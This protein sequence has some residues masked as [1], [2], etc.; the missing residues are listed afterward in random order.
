MTGKSRAEDTAKYREE[1]KADGHFRPE[2]MLGQDLAEGR[3]E[4]IIYYWLQKAS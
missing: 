1:G 3:E 4:R 2:Q